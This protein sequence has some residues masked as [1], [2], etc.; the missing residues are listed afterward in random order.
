MNTGLIARASITIAAPA[1]EVWE[2]L[3][4]P[5][6]IKAYMFGTTVTSEWAVGSPIVWTGEWEG[7]PYEDRGIILQLVRERMLEYSH[8][9]PRTGMSDLPE[10]YHIVTVHLAG[11][12]PQTHVLLYQDN[13]PTHQDRES[14]ERSWNT[15]LAALKHFVERERWQ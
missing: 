15:M 3:V 14:A 6:A 8:F 13:N 1:A 7:R 5:A 4:T 11:D 10:N 2:A 12:G 9:S